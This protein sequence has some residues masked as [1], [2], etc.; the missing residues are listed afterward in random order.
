M[1]KKS[2]KL[3]ARF[4]EL[5]AKL[6][7]GLSWWSQEARDYV[8]SLLSHVFC[9]LFLVRSSPGSESRRTIGVGL[10]S[11]VLQFSL[12]ASIVK[13]YLG[14][15]PCR[16]A[17]PRQSSGRL[18]L[19]S[20]LRPLLLKWPN[21]HFSLTL[22]SCGSVSWQKVYCTNSESIMDRKWCKC[23]QPYLY[24]KPNPYPYRLK[25]GW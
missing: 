7:V 23:H 21:K 10:R 11:S 1:E 24:F 5:E 14:W 2:T 3:G 19:F 9:C 8:A 20:L 12:A 22:G 15:S 4:K 17:T 13:C 6:R 18:H 25:L 16:H